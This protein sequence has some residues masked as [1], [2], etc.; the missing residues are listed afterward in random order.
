MHPPRGGTRGAGGFPSGSS[1]GW[2]G[3]SNRSERDE[4]GPRDRLTQ[5]TTPQAREETNAGSVYR[6]PRAVSGAAAQRREARPA[7]LLTCSSGLPGAA[8]ASH[9]HARLAPGPSSPSAQ[10]TPRV[11]LQAPPA[12]DAQREPPAADGGV[13]S[14]RPQ[15]RRAGRGGE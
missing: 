4:R 15:G 2:R 1:A 8:A 6:L 5:A 12:A 3:S 13:G 10:A 7:G 11:R 9:L 14:R